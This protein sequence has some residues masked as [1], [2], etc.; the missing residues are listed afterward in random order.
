MRGATAAASALLAFV[1]ASCDGP[2]PDGSSP[3]AEAPE[4]ATPDTESGTASIGFDHHPPGD[5]IEGS[6][7]GYTDGHVF[8]QGMRF[9]VEIAPDF[10]N[11]QVYNPGGSEGGGGGQCDAANYDYPW[12]DNFCE[13]R[14]Y[15]TPMCPTGKGHQGQDIRPPT[16]EKGKYWSVAAEAG[17]IT[18]I[19]SYSVT[20]TADSGTIYRYLHLDM[21]RL[22]VSVGT[23]LERGGRIGFVSNHFNDTPTTIHLHFEIKQNVALSD[24]TS[25]VT[26]VPPYT[27][28]VAA[29]EALLAGTP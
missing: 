15:T 26:F 21:S 12:R 9:P 20:L 28:L 3:S 14:G 17:T 16:C 8:V 27:S 6:G 10:P 1:L 29:Y 13:T 4:T 22:A 2:T 11:S 25:T 7:T 23:H 5:L 18:A 19:G 24:G